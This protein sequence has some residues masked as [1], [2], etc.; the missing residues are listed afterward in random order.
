[1]SEFIDKPR[2]SPELPLGCKDLI[3]VDEIKN[4][5]PAGR[6]LAPWYTTDKLAYVEGQLAHLIALGGKTKLVA[7]SRSYDSAS[8]MVISDDLPAS[9]LFAIW[10]NTEQQAKVR[11]YFNEAG[12]REITEPVGRWK[13][14]GCV[15]Y[16]LPSN[17]NTA[18]RLV[19]ELL[20]TG[21]GLGDLSTT[22]LSYH[23]PD[24]P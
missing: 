22:H 7:A 6:P 13:K 24:K 23:G 21:Y 11:A 2:R 4:W 9:T 18:A 10:H 3:D 1:M 16:G 19:A 12:L 15:T 5:K 20:R 14:T 8:I 17:A